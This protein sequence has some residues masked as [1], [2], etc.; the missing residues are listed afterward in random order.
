MDPDMRQLRAPLQDGGVSYHINWV[1]FP[2]EE[3]QHLGAVYTMH[4][5][6]EREYG[7][8]Q[9]LRY[10]EPNL[11]G[12]VSVIGLTKLCSLC[13]EWMRQDR[14]KQEKEEEII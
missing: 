9:V 2:N 3:V 1:Q 7:V 11:E 13:E 6:C 10:A 12:T 8:E 14:I 4:T 5:A